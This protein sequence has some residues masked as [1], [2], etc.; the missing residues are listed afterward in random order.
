[1]HLN[2]LLSK[3]FTG[4]SLHP[5]FAAAVYSSPDEAVGDIEKLLNNANIPALCLIIG[6]AV[7]IFSYFARKS[8]ANQNDNDGYNEKSYSDFHADSHE[9]KYDE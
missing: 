7:I 4:I 2:L 9:N 3:L 1:M 8:S 6:V 5:V